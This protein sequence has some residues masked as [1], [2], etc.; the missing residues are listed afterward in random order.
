MLA[1]I[2]IILGGLHL[3]F[4]LKNQIV[5]NYFMKTGEIFEGA[6]LISLIEF[7]G[8][9]GKKIKSELK[10]K[11][12]RVFSM[13]LCY[14]AFLTI[15]NS[16]KY[17]MSKGEDYE[18]PYLLIKTIRSLRF[19]GCSG[20][21][22]FSSTENYR[23]KAILGFSQ[24]QWNTTIN[25]FDLKLIATFDKF[26]PIASKTLSD[27][28][29]ATGET[30]RPGNF[31][32][33]QKCV[34]S[35]RN[36]K[37]KITMTPLHIFSIIYILIALIAAFLSYRKFKFELKDLSEKIHPS[38][39][40]QKFWMFFVFEFFQIF[41]LVKKKGLLSIREI[42][43]VYFFGFDLIT[44]FDFSGDHYWKFLTIL[45][46][47]LLGFILLTIATVVLKRFNNNSKICNNIYETL[48]YTIQP[49]LGHFLF[50]PICLMILSVYRCEEGLSNDYSQ[51]FFYRDCTQFCYKGKHET[52]IIATTIIFTL[53]MP[54][55]IFLRPYWQ[56]S[57]KEV[58]I[59]TSSA[60]FSIL[61][62]FQLILVLIKIN[63]ESYSEVITGFFIS[64]C[65][66]IMSGIIIFVKCYNYK[67]ALIFQISYLVMAF[68]A[69]AVSTF[70]F[71][72][73]ADSIFEILLVSGVG[74]IFLL[75]VGIS[76]KFPNYFFADYA[77][78][79]SLL[80]KS[81]FS[82]DFV[83]TISKIKYFSNIDASYIQDSTILNR[84][85]AYKLY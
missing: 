21:V 77:D 37:S 5:E 14:D 71:I 58:N 49:L 13:C 53:Y 60:F 33:D 24:F 1:K 40:D 43:Y 6:M 31:R 74:M 62:I 7:E 19:T 55:A 57:Q 22:Y 72:Y 64:A 82:P 80:M 83:G 50:Q 30:T 18:N 42:E 51:S 23:N 69:V 17:L 59:E 81:Q 3:H 45:L 63:T 44:F 36:P 9:Y 52:F 65:L 66:V 56:A 2:E 68:W 61:S 29:W 32:A 79:I 38:Y 47:F 8:E 73:E 35:S 46:G 26:S 67:R 39:Q 28:R 25:D 16:I 34:Y 15:H 84:T 20:E 78:S 12:N 70:S 76:S 11:Y 75:S 41:C 27:T 85:S 48:I 4:N 54:L 10:T